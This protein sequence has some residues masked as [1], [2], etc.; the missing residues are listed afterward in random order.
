M[1][2]FNPAISVVGLGKLGLPLAACFASKDHKVVGVD[3]NPSALDA[4][5][6]GISPGIEPGL[7]DLISASSSKLRCTD[8]FSDAISST[9][10]TFI[11]VPTPSDAGGRFDKDIRALPQHHDGNE[12]HP[13]IHQ[14]A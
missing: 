2:E 8:D 13:E 7:D 11:I 5:K 4:F 3:V 1:N 6:L 14:L 12:N 9:S 10:V